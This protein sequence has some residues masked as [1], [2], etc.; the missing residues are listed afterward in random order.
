MKKK[1]SPN[2]FGI[3]Y[4]N[5]DFSQ[6]E[7]WGKNQFNSSFPA[8]LACFMASKNIDLKYIKIDKQLKV[9]H[10]YISASI[11]FGAKYES[12]DLYFAF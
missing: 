7:N 10:D 12:D 1:I 3:K 11:L 9:K 4:S 2:L 8:S 6:K 5:R